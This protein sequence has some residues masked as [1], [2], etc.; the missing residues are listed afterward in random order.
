MHLE[1][2]DAND[3]KDWVVVRLK[4]ISDAD[5]DVLADYVL[6][7]IRTDTPFAQLRSDVLESLEDFLKDSKQQTLSDLLMIPPLLKKEVF[8]EL[9]SLACRYSRLR[10]RVL[11]KHSTQIIQT[12]LHSSFSYYQSNPDKE[13]SWY[14]NRNPSA[15]Q[16]E[17]EAITEALLR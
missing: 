7:L 11:S 16:S 12:W 3:L 8:A 1:E 9:V 15:A 14:C 10:Q 4:D 13:S 6:A 2:D 5:S 17:S